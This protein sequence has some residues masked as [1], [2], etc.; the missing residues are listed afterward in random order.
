VES[1]CERNSVDEYVDLKDTEK[2]DSKV[3]EHLSEEIP[4]YADVGREI[5]YG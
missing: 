3:V 5:G 4:E 1:E 2:E